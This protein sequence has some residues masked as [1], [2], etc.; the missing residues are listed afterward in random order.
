[1]GGVC[2]GDCNSCNPEEFCHQLKLKMKKLRDW[3]TSLPKSMKQVY[4]RKFIIFTQ[5]LEG[6]K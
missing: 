5:I 2:D 1:M 4:E 6:L 3:F